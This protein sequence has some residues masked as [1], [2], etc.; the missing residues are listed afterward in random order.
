MAAAIR[1]NLKII[2]FKVME[3]I[4]VQKAKN[5]KV[6]G[7]IIVNMDR[8][9]FSG[10][11]VDIIQVAFNL[12][13]NMVKVSIAGPMADATSEVGKIIKWTELVSIWTKMEKYRLAFGQKVKENNGFKKTLKNRIIYH[14][15]QSTQSNN[16]FKPKSMIFC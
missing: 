13:K 4:R 6:T 5:T 1:D 16:I 14:K 8:A 7:L 12:T 11:M 3:N 10:Q 2:I 9:S 15:L